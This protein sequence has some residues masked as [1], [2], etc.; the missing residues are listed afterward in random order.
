[1][2]KPSEL[3]GIAV[4]IA[5][6][7]EKSNSIPSLIAA[8]AV[9]VGAAVAACSALETDGTLAA[10]CG[11]IAVVFEWI[12]ARN[13][14]VFACANAAILVAVAALS[15]VFWD[16]FAAL[17]NRAFELSEKYQMYV[18]TRFSA[19][20]ATETAALATI[21]AAV[22]AIIGV[23]AACRLRSI[24]VA[25]FAIFVAFA[26]Y[27]GL[28]P[29][30]VPTIVFCAATLVAATTHG[31]ESMAA[32]VAILVTMAVGFALFPGENADL[33]NFTEDI[34]DRFGEQLLV[35]DSNTNSDEI[36][37]D[38]S[39][40]MVKPNDL[41]EISDLRA[42]QGDSFS[43]STLGAAQSQRI[44]VWMVLLMAALILAAVSFP[45][46]RAYLGE[47]RKRKVFAS[48][49]IARAVDAM[50]RASLERLAAAGLQRRNVPPAL[51]ADEVASMADE[52]C[53]AAFVEAA[54]LRDEALYSGHPLDESHRARMRE[55]MELT[56]RETLRHIGFRRRAALR[57]G[58]L[59]G[60]R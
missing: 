29:T 48:D 56:E 8:L 24:F 21:F 11:A 41:G 46:V 37:P 12:C 15:V 16:S 57:L 25:I 59:G 50:F 22:G 47:R 33:H 36:P 43:G 40:L 30:A 10:V 19:G 58:L 5:A 27:F 18:Y 51:Y 1:M 13:R 54:R 53:R 52:G 44:R 28:F 55:F 6:P 60:A 32:V 14:T 4:E 26:V 31:R 3:C 45:I 35:P 49:D 34:R 17:A 23:A 20:N 42:E 39:F 7:R 2:K 38:L 9:T